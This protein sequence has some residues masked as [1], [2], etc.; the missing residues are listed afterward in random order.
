MQIAKRHLLSKQLKKHGLKPEQ[1]EISEEILHLMVS[2]YTREAGVRRLEQIIAKLCRKI[3]KRIV[4]TK[5]NK[6][7]ITKDNLQDI[8]GH[9]K[10]KDDAISKKAPTI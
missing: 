3:A 10:Y 8:L 1:V 5:T 4:E 2:G 7:T 6:I 9:A